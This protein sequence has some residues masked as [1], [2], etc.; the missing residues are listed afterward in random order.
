MSKRITEKEKMLI[1][2]RQK[3]YEKR[4]KRKSPETVNIDIDN[5]LSFKDIEHNNLCNFLLNSPFQM[6]N[7]KKIRKIENNKAYIKIP[8]VFSFISNPNATLKSLKSLL[9]V[10]KMNNLKE[11]FFDHSECK[12]LGVCASAVND[13][14]LLNIIE[15]HKRKKHN[16]EIK[17]TIGNAPL[18][19]KNMLHTS[20]VLKHLNIED[21]NILVDNE[22][23]VLPLQ[24]G[25]RGY[26]ASTNFEQSIV[27]QKI[28]QYID[29][30]L[31][32]NS[33]SLNDNGTELF[34]KLI[35]ESIDNCEQHS[36]KYKEWYSLGHYYKEEQQEYG[37][38]HLAIFNFGQTIYE[39]LKN[40]CK[41]KDLLS[42]LENKSNMH[43]KNDSY[44]DEEMLW[45]LYALQDGISKERL[46]DVI[47]DRGSGT[48]R[49]IES[50]QEIGNTKNGKK[51][52]MCI[53]SGSTH[54]LFDGDYK[55]KY[56]DFDGGSR[57]II[58]FNKEN[59]L[60]KPPDNSKI[61]K[62]NGFF[63]GTIISLQFY[64]DR[65]FLETLI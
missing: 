62:L 17:G 3:D 4:C 10:Y 37:E 22:I 23:E 16:L 7:L 44:W 60:D 12:D 48:L 51:A 5:K 59:S 39:G 8:Q 31:N 56:E 28:I 19:V 9:L 46:D 1:A 29:K 36:G 57:G 6:H 25:G 30:C 18:K 32:L 50:F 53:I 49:F 13:L 27:T 65:K 26:N 42:N 55:L 24:K 58:A 43:I 47:D 2:I 35:G 41:S 14:I 20:G 52:K 38:C 33:F 63:A 45:S 54:I 15:H 61:T 34:G 40:D 21:K 11:V 64:I